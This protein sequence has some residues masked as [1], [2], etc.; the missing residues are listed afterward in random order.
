[1]GGALRDNNTQVLLISCSDPEFIGLLQ[2]FCRFFFHLCHADVFI[3]SFDREGQTGLFHSFIEETSRLVESQVLFLLAMSFSGF[4]E[5]TSLLVERCTMVE[6]KDEGQTKQYSSR[7]GARY[8]GRRVE[9]KQPSHCRWASM[10]S[11]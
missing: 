6:I 4:F 10:S 2:D 8:E 9:S 3:T 5:E 1:M 11:G 7:D